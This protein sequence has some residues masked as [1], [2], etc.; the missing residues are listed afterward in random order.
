MMLRRRDDLVREVIKVDDY[1]TAVQRRFERRIRTFLGNY[2]AR[3][4]AMMRRPNISKAEMFDITVATKIANDLKRIMIDAGSDDLIAE[5]VD[6]FG[7]ATKSALQYFARVSGAKADLAGVDKESLQSLIS[8]T[9]GTLR[10]TVDRRYLFPVQEAVFQAAMGSINMPTAIDSIMSRAEELSEAQVTTLITDSFV[11]YQRT[12]TVQ[13]GDAL[14]LE[15]F[16]YTGPDDDVTSDQCRALLGY[17][18][19]GLE[20]GFYKDEITADLHPALKGNPLIAGGHV[21]CRHRFMPVTEDFAVEMGF[22]P[23]RAE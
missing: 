5:F 9:E 3:I 12:V 13:K 15:V 16:I 21:N 18:E 14:G 10:E 22:E 2:G 7:P 17:D 6:E 8:F 1:R 20:G 11:Q 23:R 19:H 4:E